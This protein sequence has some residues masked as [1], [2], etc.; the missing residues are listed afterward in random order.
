MN[1]RRKGMPYP[2]LA[3]GVEAGEEQVAPGRAHAL[4][5]GQGSEDGAQ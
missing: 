5:G 1:G 3:R 2:L 4:T